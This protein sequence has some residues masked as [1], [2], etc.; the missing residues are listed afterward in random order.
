MKIKFKNLGPIES[1]EIDFNDLKGINL[2]IGKN[3]TGKTYLSN[4]LYSFFKIMRQIGVPLFMLSNIKSNDIIDYNLLQEKCE[5]EIELNLKQELITTFHVH[6]D[7]FKNF[8][9][10]KV[11]LT[12]EI[13]KLKEK[14]IESKILIMLKDKNKTIITKIVNHKIIFEI[15]DYY[16]NSKNIKLEY[17]ETINS[18]FE[19]KEVDLELLGLYSLLNKYFF[20]KNVKIHFFPAERSGIMLFYNQMLES[21]NNILRKL[22]LTQDMNLLKKNSRYSEP[23][24]E[25]IIR[26]NQLEEYEN[27]DETEIYRNLVKN[28]DIQNIIEGEIII[29]SNQI[30]YKN[31]E[32]VELNMGLVSSTVKTLAGFFLYLKYQAQEGDIIFIDEIELNLHPENQRKVMRLINYLSKQGLKFVISTHSPII[33]QEINNM[34]MF[35]KCKHKIDDEIIEEYS[36]DREN[37]GLRQEDVNVYFLN[38]KTI[39]IAEFGEDGII[40]DTFNEVLGEIDNLYQELLFAMEEE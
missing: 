1:G 16:E 3:N 34:I 25:Y 5:K 37:Y 20:D 39:E 36:I 19:T 27:K 21:Q 11:D 33:T 9:I 6:S 8:E 13:D 2:I 15:K 29:K 30:I 14:N 28:I 23:V 40:T 32:D 18:D 12:D 22:E 17:D 26:L 4:L 10:V 31:Q 38:N 24:N 35:E 7:F